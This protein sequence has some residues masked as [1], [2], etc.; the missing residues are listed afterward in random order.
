VQ[1]APENL[2]SQEPPA[3]KRGDLFGRIVGWGLWPVMFVVVVFAVAGT[4]RINI[5]DIALLAFLTGVSSLAVFVRSRI[6]KVLAASLLLVVS[7]FA[8]SCYGS[9]LR[10]VV[11]NGRN[12]SP[13]PGFG[14]G[15]HALFAAY[16]PFMPYLLV[17][18]LGLF[19]IAVT[20]A[21]RK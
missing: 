17:S 13:D 5:F 4:D 19:A 14:A 12:Q 18:A 6:V 7:L 15:V 1:S 10:T 16:S 20:S 9:A 21:Y 11:W 3:G 8:V 2:N